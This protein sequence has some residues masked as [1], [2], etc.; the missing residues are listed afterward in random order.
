MP[1]HLGVFWASVEQFQNSQSPQGVPR[2]LHHLALPSCPPLPAA[3]VREG[4]SQVPATAIP[5]FL[6]H[7]SPE[8][9]VTFS[10][11]Q[12]GPRCPPPL[13]ALDMSRQAT[14]ECLSGENPKVAAR[15]GQGVGG[16]MLKLGSTEL[17]SAEWYMPGQEA[18]SPADT[19]VA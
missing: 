12:Y 13:G 2:L 14:Q 10:T 11:P 16:L 6:A 17:S 3:L 9:P 19:D 1:W 8:E 4:V 7:G 15:A 5:L 18:E